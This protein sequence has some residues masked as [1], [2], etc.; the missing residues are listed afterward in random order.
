MLSYIIF[1]QNIT[2]LCYN[3]CKK[4]KLEIKM[5]CNVFLYKIETIC[6]INKSL[7]LMLYKN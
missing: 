6:N 7:N 4:E 2:N 3:F 1:E 5:V